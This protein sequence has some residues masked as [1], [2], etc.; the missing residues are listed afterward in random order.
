LGYKKNYQNLVVK[1]LILLSFGYL[2]SAVS[3]F[4]RVSSQFY[5]MEKYF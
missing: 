1:K 2:L 4:F 5:F 3:Q